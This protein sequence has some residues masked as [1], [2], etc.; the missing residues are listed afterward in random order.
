MSLEIE[1]IQEK[2]QYI[3]SIQPAALAIRQADGWVCRLGR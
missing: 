3:L 2:L 1:E